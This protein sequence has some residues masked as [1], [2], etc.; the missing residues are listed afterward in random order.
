MHE[1]I[2]DTIGRFYILAN[3]K[4]PADLTHKEKNIYAYSANRFTQSPGAC[5]R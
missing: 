4:L 3:S 1:K 2:K 5:A